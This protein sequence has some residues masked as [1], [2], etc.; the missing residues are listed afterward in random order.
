[1][2]DGDDPA[3]ESG[4]GS[5]GTAGGGPGSDAGNASDGAAPENGSGTDPTEDP[6]QPRVVDGPGGREVVVP[7]RLYK[8]VTVFGTLLAIVGVVGGFSLL[9]AATN[10]G[11]APVDEISLPVALAGL[12]L[13]LAGALVYVYSTRFRA[14]GMGRSKAGSDQGGDDG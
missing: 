7:M 3:D 5:P 12:G 10:R 11:R 14:A 13:I 2:P 8:T 9:D 6:D 4:N 1:M